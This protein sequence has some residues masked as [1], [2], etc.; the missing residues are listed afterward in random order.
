MTVSGKFSNHILKFTFRLNSLHQIWPKASSFNMYILYN[1]QIIVT[2]VVTID[3]Y[4]LKF[5]HSTRVY[6]VPICQVLGLLVKLEKQ[7]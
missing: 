1:P 6:L 4:S 3:N 5:I 2:Y 7:V